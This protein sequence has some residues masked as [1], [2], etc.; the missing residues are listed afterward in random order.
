LKILKLYF[1]VNSESVKRPD[2]I[3]RYKP[4]S[5]ANQGA[6]SQED[7]MPDYLNILGMIFSMLGLMMK[8][9]YCGKTRDHLA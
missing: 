7:L 5:T 9:K 3:V 1:L 6:A 4:P 2:R 8:L